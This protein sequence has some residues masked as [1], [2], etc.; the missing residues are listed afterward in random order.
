VI[1]KASQA[2]GSG[3]GLDADFL[4]GLNSSAFLSSSAGAVTG[5]HVDESTLGEVPS[6]T[7]A[8]RAANADTVGGLAPDALLSGAT[9][10]EQPLAFT[11]R[12][13]SAIQSNVTIPFSPRLNLRVNNG[14]VT[15]CSRAAVPNSTLQYVRYLN[16][17]R[18]ADGLS[19][20]LGGTCDTVVGMGTNEDMELI[21]DGSRFMLHADGG[22]GGTYTL[23]II[24]LRAPE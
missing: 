23:R 19:M 7:D 18:T 14:T 22:V 12:S 21:G 2:D 1:D 3:S 9:A 10:N 15:L 11:H 20:H 4:D 8:D 16:G 13:V 24:G 17:V 5:T 6:A